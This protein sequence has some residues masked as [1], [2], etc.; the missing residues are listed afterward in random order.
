M[1]KSFIA[2]GLL[3][4]SGSLFAQR[5]AI[6][7]IAGTG[8]SPG[9]SG[10]LGPAL[11]AQFHN[12]IRVAL[13]SN[14]NIFLN[15]L[16]NSSIREVFTNGTVN[17]VTGNGSP[18]FSGDGKTAVG[19]QLSAPND[20]AIDSHD[21]LYIADTGNSRVR[22][23]SHGII[24]TFAGS[25]HGVPGG[26]LGDGGAATNAKFILPTGVAVDKNGNVY[27]SDIGNAT[28]RKV[29]PGGVI[30]TFAGSGFLSSGTY[31]GEGGPATQALLGLP[32]SL[33]TDSAGNVYIV[34]IGFSRLFKIGSDGVIH[35]VVS[36]F[37]AQNCAVDDAGIIYVVDYSTHTVQKIL[38]GG[39]ALWIGGDG[40][41]GYSGDF[42]IGTS[43]NMAEPYGVALDKSGNVYVAEAANA[44]IRKLS[45]V[46]FSIGAI[47]NAATIQPFDAPSS[48]SG[49]ATIPISPGEIITLF[50]T[51]LGP[52]TLVSNSPGP[53]GNFG[54]SVAGTTVSIGGTL[55]PIIYTS[56]TLVSA[57]VPYAVNGLTSTNVFVTY[58]GQQSATS[59]VPVAP[60]APGLFTAN[61]SGSGQALAVNLPS[62]IL[63]TPANPIPVG[64]F[65]LLYATGEGQTT[66]AGV[67]GKPA[68]APLPTPILTVSATVN[69]IPANVSFAGGAP[70]F[71]AGVLQVNIQI[72]VGVASGSAQ[73]KLII[74]NVN[75]PQV[76]ISVK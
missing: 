51:G 30:T 33:S 38:P 13:D 17:S 27:I 48:G 66:P 50:G 71:V 53:D 31:R 76:T 35:T 10:D 3:I 72:P 62:G 40:A 39:T 9:W 44:V 59:T 25:T 63:N 42:G 14:G 2:C 49:D 24:N 47:A 36:N 41:S 16:G 29:S 5:Y 32:Y 4:A 73:L 45:P 52:A 57:I 12:P 75:S 8:G 43:A 54:T 20:I 56:S 19:A 21:N 7:T 61:S 6:T 28:V 55:A 74:N 34:D 69:N 22:I 23:V 67:D 11:S 68:T 1:K 18:G 64:S 70:G 46:P 37:P 15:D 65:L 60:A 26:D 58:Q